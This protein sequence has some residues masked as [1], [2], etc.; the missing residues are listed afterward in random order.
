VEAKG[1]GDKMTVTELKAALVACK[2]MPE[3]DA[4][5]LETVGAMR[6]AG[7]DGYKAIQD[8]FRKQKNR[9][10]RIPLKDRSW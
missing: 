1:R 8:I 6:I 5:R 10:L 3:L 7:K 4:L 2:T 9:L